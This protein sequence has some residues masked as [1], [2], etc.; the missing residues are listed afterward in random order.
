VAGHDFYLTPGSSTLA[1]LA[2]IVLGRAAG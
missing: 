2:P 1:A